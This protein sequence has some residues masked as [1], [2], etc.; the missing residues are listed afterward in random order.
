MRDSPMSDD[1]IPEPSPEGSPQETPKGRRL[2]IV[3]CAVSAIVTLAAVV[4]IAGRLFFASEEEM[5]AKDTEEL[6]EI[7]PAAGT[8]PKN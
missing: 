3:L 8:I 2:G 1:T 7:A 4:L 6:Q 5:R